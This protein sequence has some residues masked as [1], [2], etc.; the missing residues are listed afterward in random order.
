MKR[1]LWLVLLAVVAAVAVP[2]WASDNNT[3]EINPPTTQATRKHK[4]HHRHHHKNHH[5]NHL[6]RDQYPQE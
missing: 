3:N 1:L 6:A 5:K 2:T 4:R